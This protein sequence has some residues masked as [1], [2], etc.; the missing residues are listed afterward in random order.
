M[1]E[2][3]SFSSGRS[4]VKLCILLGEDVNKNNPPIDNSYSACEK[5]RCIGEK[6]EILS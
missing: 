1:A 6:H 5:K 2:E 3:R 4:V